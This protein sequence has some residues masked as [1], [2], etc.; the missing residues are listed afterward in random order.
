[1]IIQFDQP[2]TV[3]INFTNIQNTTVKINNT[4]WPA[5]QIKILHGRFSDGSLLRFNWT[6]KN[7][8]VT[9]LKIQLNFEN[10]EQVSYYSEDPER[11]TV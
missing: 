11:I 10:P 4:Q 5:I 6:L 3:P 2:M 8:T 9:Q 1:M 7:Y